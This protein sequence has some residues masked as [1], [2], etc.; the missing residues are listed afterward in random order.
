MDD[1]RKKKKKKNSPVSKIVFRLY[2]TIPRD[3]VRTPQKLYDDLNSVFE[4]DFDPCPYMSTFDGLALKDW[5]KMNYVNP[6][7]SKVKRWLAKGVEEWKKGNDSVFL[8]PFG[9]N[10]K[11]FSR[12]VFSHEEFKIYLITKRVKFTGYSHPFFMGLCLIVMDKKTKEECLMKK[13]S[14]FKKGKLRLLL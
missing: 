5:G 14:L 3:N 12:L 11:Y 2:E 4:F 8:I 9:F 7:Y 6:P 13:T 10:A 1:I